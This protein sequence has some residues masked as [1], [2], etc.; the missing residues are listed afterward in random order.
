MTRVC[1]T[2]NDIQIITGK[3]ERQCRNIFKD[4]KV[5]YKK[6]K[7]QMVTVDELS[8]YLGIHI[9]VIRNTIK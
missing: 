8:N 2:P 7:H 1:I 5:F 3:S 9:D 4:I 6:E